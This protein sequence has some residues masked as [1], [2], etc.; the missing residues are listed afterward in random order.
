MEGGRGLMHVFL[1]NQIAENIKTNAIV[2]FFLDSSS[3]TLLSVFEFYFLIL[4]PSFNYK[5][6]LHFREI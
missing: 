5:F 3:N 1:T 4:C 6:H 2:D